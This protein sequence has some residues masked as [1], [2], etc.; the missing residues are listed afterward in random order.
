MKKQEMFNRM[1][2]TECLICGLMWKNYR[3]CVAHRIKK[4]PNRL[5]TG[6]RYKVKNGDTLW[7]IAV[8]RF[9]SGDR[10]RE[11]YEVNREVIKNVD[12][13]LPG[14]ELIMP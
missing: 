4:H 9:G 3:A 6:D 7:R 14:T 1:K 8:Y 12:A 10:W 13:I 5:A 2:P 11:I